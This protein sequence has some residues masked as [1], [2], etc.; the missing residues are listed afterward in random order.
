MK[1]VALL[2][3]AATTAQAQPIVGDEVVW[4]TT[5]PEATYKPVPQAAR[6]AADGY[7]L[8]VTWSEVADSVS[9]V[10]AGRLDGTGHLM[11]VGVC[12]T[13]IGDAAT[14]TRFGDR[15]LA[16][17]LEPGTA[18]PRS[19]LVTAALDRN[20]TVLSTR[21]IGSTDGPPIVR[22]GR[23]RAFVG[24]GK[25]LYELDADGAAIHVYPTG[26]DVID[27]VDAAGEQVGYVVHTVTH[28]PPIC[29]G[30]GCTNQFDRYSL[31][32]TWLA[33][34]TNAISYDAP[35]ANA[36]PGVGTNGDGF[37]VAWYE[38]TRLVKGAFFESTFET[39]LLSRRGP[40]VLDAGAQPQVAWDGARWLVVW[41]T[42]DGIEGAAVLPDH[43]VT[44]FTISAHGRRPAVTA[45]KRGE[46][47]VTY[48]VAGA[49]ERR[50]A[51]RVIG[52]GPSSRERA[53]R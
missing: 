38:P 44:P 28:F 12:S 21:T 36:L 6:V 47:V 9:R 37:L 35:S 1:L 48:E 31:K 20:L 50:L 30:L 10:C 13:G 22:S 3:L 15:Y 16:A 49:A 14:I 34:L 51:S 53:V 8:L 32:F 41:S 27:D 5:S 45:A 25:S 52:L 46:F 2:F 40:E 26:D 19:L 29:H 7:T 33:T 18:T 42:G 17:W 23:S 4:R 43:S 11:S 24:S 39:L